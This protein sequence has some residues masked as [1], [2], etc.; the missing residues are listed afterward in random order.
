MITQEQVDEMSA[1]IW[2]GYEKDYIDSKNYTPDPLDWLGSNWQGDIR[3]SA[4]LS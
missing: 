1:E 3:I 4:N 2:E